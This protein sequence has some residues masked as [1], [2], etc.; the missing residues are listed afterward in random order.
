MSVGSTSS[1]TKP[2]RAQSAGSDRSAPATPARTPVKAATP[3]KTPSQ[4]KAESA[5]KKAVEKSKTTPRTKLTPKTTPMHSPAVESKPLPETKEKRPSPSKEDKTLET[6]SRMEKSKVEGIND[7][8]S[9]T[10]IKSGADYFGADLLVEAGVTDDQQQQP[11]KDTDAPAEPVSEDSQ[12]LVKSSVELPSQTKP[13]VEES[14]IAAG[15]T[16]EKTESQDKPLTHT[17]ETLAEDHK[18]EDES[19]NILVSLEKVSES[20]TEETSSKPREDEKNGEQEK[21]LAQKAAE[22]PVTGYATEEEY[23]AALAEKRRLAR[24][25]KEREQELERQRKVSIS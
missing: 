7:N 10:E 9:I 2:T 4:V 13:L 21:T 15:P 8:V 20:I 25:A 6:K 12:A 18:L 5:A 19:V 17:S 11:G 22:K 1:T 3:K 23:K 14:V 24:E 16:V